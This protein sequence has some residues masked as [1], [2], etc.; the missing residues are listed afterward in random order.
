ML[1]QA[2]KLGLRAG[3]LAQSSDRGPH[4]KGSLTMSLSI[5]LS[6]TFSHS[7]ARRAK[8]RDSATTS[9]QRRHTFRPSLE[10]LEIRLTL[11]MTT[12]ASF[13]YPNGIWPDAG[14]AMDSSGNLYGTTQTDGAYG[15][16]GTVFE[17]AKATGAMTTLAS[18]NSA[19]GIE[20][21][22]PLIVDSSGNLY[23]TT[24]SNTANN[25]NFYYGTVFE[26]AK[27]SGT[28]TTLASFNGSTGGAGSVG[29]LIMD[30]SGNLFGTTTAGGDL[31]LNSGFGGG[32]VFELAA[33]S[34][35][36][37]T[38]ATFNGTNGEEPSGGVIMDS[39]GNLYGTTTEGGASGDGTVF[40]VAQGSG[41]ITTLAS[42]DGTNGQYPFDGLIK[43]SSGD[44]YGTTG[45]GGASGYGTVFEVAS[46]SGA[47]TTLASFNGKNG[48][49]PYGGL[50]MDSNGDLYGTTSSG[51]PTWNPNAGVYGDGTVFELA[52]RSST[53]TT[54]ASFN[55]TNGEDPKAG[56]IRDSSGNLYGTTYLGGTAGYGTVFE[57]ASGSGTIT[58]LATF[59]NDGKS[60]YDGLIMD[61]SGNLYGTTEEGGAYGDGTVFELAQGSGTL[62]TLA[63]FNLTNGYYPVA[64]LIMDSNGDLYGTTILGGASDFGTVFELA[65]GSGTITTLASF[66]DDDGLEPE[67]GADHGQQRQ[68]VWHNAF[69]E[70]WLWHGFRGGQGQRYDHHA[71]LVQWHQRLRSVGRADHGQQR[72]SVWHSIWWRRLERRHGFRA[73]PGQRQNHH[74][75]FVQ[76]H[77]RRRS[78]CR[79][80][81][82]Q[83]RQSVRHNVWWRRLERR[84][85][86]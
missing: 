18:F 70:R 21:E 64:G 10:G 56:L 31:F 44:L 5:L 62:T 55:G 1:R 16:Y 27:G 12:L 42:F 34:G 69:R 76:R 39:S 72:Q 14:L 74:A 78:V 85:G 86:F 19:D 83:Q 51:G 48:D 30:S 77:Q 66:N 2:L 71:G 57:L 75:R 38:L 13:G 43:D 61:S 80:G 47:I 25:G 33:G 46:G 40:K 4:R 35:T 9:P 15:P 52:H 81:H 11:S 50:I 58:T 32:T 6:R 54:L 36:I 82:G 60:P 24:L 20:P 28:I 41:A 49:E 17:I 23:G 84:H 65:K 79:R 29:G 53:I 8:R 45:N 37:T 68:S 63:S 3:A 22:G 59:N 26:L 73:G 7:Q 67:G